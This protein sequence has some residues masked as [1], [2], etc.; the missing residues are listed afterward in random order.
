MSVDCADCGTVTDK[1]QAFQPGA[2]I[3]MWINVRLTFYSPASG[4]GR[5]SGLSV[6]FVPVVLCV[7]AITIGIFWR[8]MLN[9]A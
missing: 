6:A 1:L 5:S 8:L 9:P 2:A 3:S 4:V 7:L